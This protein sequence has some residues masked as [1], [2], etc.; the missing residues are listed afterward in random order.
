MKNEEN[1]N[2]MVC[3]FRIKN[4]RKWGEWMME[5]EYQLL[6]VTEIIVN[7]DKRK[8]SYGCDDFDLG[9]LKAV[10]WLYQSERTWSPKQAEFRITQQYRSWCSQRTEYVYKMVSQEAE[11][12]SA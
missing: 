9:Y 5:R 10:N 1:F 12:V 11:Q 3:E 6:E 7:G 2:C 8:P 4:G